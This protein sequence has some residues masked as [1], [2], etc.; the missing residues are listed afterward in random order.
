[1]PASQSLNQ[2]LQLEL[3]ETFLS[4]T[5]CKVLE[6]FRALGSKLEDYAK[7]EVTI[8]FHP[9]QI[10]SGGF[11]VL[12]AIANDGLL[13]SQFETGTSNGG[14]TAFPGGDRWKW[15]S[16]AFKGLY[17]SC[18][19][20]ERP[21][22]GALNHRL[23]QSGGAPRFGSSHFKLRR[24]LLERT[25]FCYP[26][27]WVGP[28]DYGMA[29]RVKNLIEMADSDT[30]DLL[31]NYVEA[32]IHGPIS[33][34]NDVEALVVDP[35][36]KGTEIEKFAEKIKCDIRWHKGF[37][38]SIEEFEFHADYRGA[39]YVDLAKLIVVKGHVNP[40]LIGMA[41]SQG[42]YDPQD[43]KKVWHYLARFGDL[44]RVV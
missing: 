16:K 35:I 25:T 29:D 20:S 27:S 33:V 13:R 42:T 34:E 9:D 22:Y 26:E 10:T 32:H 44:N 7:L 11:L 28:L 43:L 23:S 36:Y 17:D 6:N 12:E 31:D 40:K 18:H 21:K 41:V 30:L 8:N 19:V 4:A 39:E 37:N 15:E 3:M 5:Q 38:L 2:M 1:M 24:H 14:L